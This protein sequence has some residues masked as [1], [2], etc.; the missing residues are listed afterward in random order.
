MNQNLSNEYS[1]LLVNKSK[2]IKKNVEDNK[3][4]AISVSSV[5]SVVI[6]LKLFGI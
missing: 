4:D 3:V 1:C 5:C 6:I 2:G